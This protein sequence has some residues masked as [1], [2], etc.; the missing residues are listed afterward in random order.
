MRYNLVSPGSKHVDD[1]SIS[2]R[3]KVRFHIMLLSPCIELAWQISVHGLCN[4]EIKWRWRTVRCNRPD[5]LP[6]G[7]LHLSE[8]MCKL[9]V[10]VTPRKI[11]LASSVI[12]CEVYILY[13]CIIFMYY[14]LA[15]CEI[16]GSLCWLKTRRG[17][18]KKRHLSCHSL[19][20]YCN[21]LDPDLID[22][23]TCE[24]IIACLPW[25]E[26]ELVYKCNQF[27]LM[28][29]S[30]LFAYKQEHEFPHRPRWRA[31]YGREWQGKLFQSKYTHRLGRIYKVYCNLIR[32]L[33]FSLVGVSA[34]IFYNCW[35]PLIMCSTVW[36][37][38]LW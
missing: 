10:R 21:L 31:T 32:L 13:V 19:L 7:R 8:R 1:D 38:S 28:N 24:T 30:F 20:T 9:S 34:F 29:K 37:S 16:M 22:V 26:M 18:S 23:L 4:V 5:I 17:T 33:V 12:S 6:A 35:A 27:S 11:S 36:N 14:S 2:I 25:A 3:S 15:S